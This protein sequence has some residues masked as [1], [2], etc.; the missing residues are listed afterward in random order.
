[1]PTPH[2]IL[3]AIAPETL[4]LDQGRVDIHVDLAEA[5]TGP[6]FGDARNHAVA[7]LAA[8]TLTLGQRRGAS[9]PIT[10]EKEGDLARS[11]ATQA[12]AHGLDATSY[13]AELLRLR[14]Q[15]V[16]AARTVAV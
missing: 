11:Y 8:H 2:E 15:Y 16:F 10:S 5:Q 13:G 12:M 3:A 9:G 1:M 7:L 6:V 4:N 14:R